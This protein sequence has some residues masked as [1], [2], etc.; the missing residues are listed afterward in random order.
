MGM[1]RPVFSTSLD[2]PDGHLLVKIEALRP[3]LR[4]CFSG[5]AA[6]ITR[7]TAND[8]PK[9]FH[10]S[11][12][13]T[14][15]VDADLDS[16]GAH[17]RQSLEM[18]SGLGGDVPILRADLDHVL[19]WVERDS[20]ELG[21][22][23]SKLEESEFT[24][25]GRSVASMQMVPERLKSTESIVNHVYSLITGQRWD[26]M[27]SARGVS[28]AAAD[29]IIKSSVVDTVGNDTEWP[30]HLLSRSR[31]PDLHDRGGLRP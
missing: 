18:A 20:V 3:E 19:R 22:V 9:L 23:V 12:A 4:L 15:R 2:D 30:G 27:M 7:R 31:W 11:G 24:V 25:I 28:K 13:Q 14:A 5:I 16:I 29:L 26:L 6:V 17:R 10:S 21:E 1:T 8:I